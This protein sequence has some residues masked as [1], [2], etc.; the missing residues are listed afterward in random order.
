VC[1][2]ERERDRDRER[3]RHRERERD[4]ETETD[5][6]RQRQEDREESVCLT[7]PSFSLPNWLFCSRDRDRAVRSLYPWVGLPVLHLTTRDGVKWVMVS[8]GME[9]D[10]QWA[11]GVDGYRIMLELDMTRWS[12]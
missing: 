4:R 2:R 7:T 12:V 9:P 1:V 5:R 3:Q 6:K 11:E 8:R 10:L